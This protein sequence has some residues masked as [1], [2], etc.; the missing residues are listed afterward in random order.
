MSRH[1]I[2]TVNMQLGQIEEALEAF[3]RR[4]QEILD[5][6][7]NRQRSVLKGQEAELECTEAMLEED[8]N[9]INQLAGEMNV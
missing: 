4:Q 1:I 2:E 5:E 3:E 7:Y 6:D 8:I 9:Y